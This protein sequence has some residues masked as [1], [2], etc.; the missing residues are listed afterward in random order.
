MFR[1]SK[2]A[3]YAI[4]GVLYLSGKEDDGRPTGIE[5]IAKAQGVP[6]AY[7]AKLFQTLGKKGY[8]RSVR[9]H[10]GGFVLTKKPGEIS[11]LDI[12]EA[13]EGPIF[14]NDC[15]INEGYCVNDNVCPVHDVWG[16][17]QKRLLGF[18]RSCNF[19][20]LSEAGVRKRNKL[21]K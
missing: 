10:D 1:L 4:R 2:A 17:A 12:I 6:S 19:K 16:E 7:L 15:L 14:L 5:E 3:E 13:V 21:K 20:E 8:V 9:G 11:F 18:F